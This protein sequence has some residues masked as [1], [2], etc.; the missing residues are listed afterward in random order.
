MAAGQ[1]HRDRVGSR[2]DP[3]IEQLLAELDDLV[4]NDDRGLVRVP[5]RTT[6][7]SLEPRLALG[8]VAPDELVDP[9]GDT[10]KSRATW[11]F[12]RPSIR[13][14]VTTSLASDIANPFFQRS[15]R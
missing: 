2:V 11:A 5:P 15:A 14:A 13:T 6:R 3:Q 4:F 8:V 9:P 12:V 10:P 1:V 7:P